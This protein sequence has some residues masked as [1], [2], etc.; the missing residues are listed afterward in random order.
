MASKNPNPWIAIWTEPRNTVRSIVSYK[1][2]YGFWILSGLTGWPMSVQFFHVLSSLGAISYLS[3]L[4]LT[5][6]TAPLFGA[7][8]NLLFSS[9][10]YGIGKC[11]KGQASFSEILCSV[12]WSNITNLFSVFV[13]I[14]VLTYFGTN[15]FSSTVMQMPIHPYMIYVLLILRVLQTIFFGWTIYLLVVSISEVQRFSLGRSVANVLVA[16]G[17]LALATVWLS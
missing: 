9:V 5:L 17:V 12:A 4:I 16:G 3:I 8:T 6:V 1:P 2:L 7:L 13:T 10:M 11:L 14:V 15:W